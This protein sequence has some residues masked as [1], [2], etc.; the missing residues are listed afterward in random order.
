M[1]NEKRS[2]TRQ[3]FSASVFPLSAKKICSA[4]GAEVMR[5]SAR[6]CNTCGKIL[7]EDYEPLDNLRSSYNLQGTSFGF[8]VEET[9]TQEDLFEK[10]ENQVAHTAWACLVYSMVPY[11]GILFIPFTFVVGGFGYAVA[12]KHP[13]L[14]GKKLALISIGLSF[15]VLSV[16]MLLWWL[17]YVV[18]NLGRQF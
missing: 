14:G 1:E 16:Q 18:P 9:E 4:C 15:V 10:N 11:L 13:K 5:Q 6:F 17:L 2:Q 7:F 12:V 8:E 3:S